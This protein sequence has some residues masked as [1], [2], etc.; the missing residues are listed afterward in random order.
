MVG[1]EQGFFSAI[2]KI[3]G[4]IEVECRHFEKFFAIRSTLFL[5]QIKINGAP[6]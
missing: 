3:A 5:Q 6:S 1:D 2:Y 4:S